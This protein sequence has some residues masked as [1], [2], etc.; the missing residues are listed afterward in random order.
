M[1]NLSIVPSVERTCK[2][3]A[4]YVF[5]QPA[6]WGFFIWREFSF[7]P[8]ETGLVIVYTGNGKGKTTAAVGMGIRAVGRGQKV[9]MIQF[10]KQPGLLYGEA[11][12]LA[13]CVPEFEV[14]QVG[15]GFSMR[16]G[17]FSEEDVEAAAL[18][19]QIAEQSMNG[20]YDLVILDELN[21]AVAKGLV[22]VD[23]VLD[24]LKKRCARVNVVITGRYAPEVLLSVAD[25][26]SEIQDVKHHYR[27]G[28]KSRA[29]VDV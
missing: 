1:C 7:M 8:E 22:D 15:K 29:G 28:V 2:Q 20:E 14:C 27:A 21:V 26:V 16:K 3:L 13:K 23:R 11:V 17:G 24:M 4:C 6:G 18:G 10:I 25:T 5:P 12:A 9:K 19:M